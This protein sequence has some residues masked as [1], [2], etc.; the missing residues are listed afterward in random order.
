MWRNSETNHRLESSI[1]LKNKVLLQKIVPLMHQIYVKHI[2]GA[3]I[4]KVNCVTAVGLRYAR[5]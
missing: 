2:I 4:N 3:S 1:N 5:I